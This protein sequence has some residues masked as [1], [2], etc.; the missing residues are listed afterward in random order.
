MD[1]L[2]SLSDGVADKTLKKA[3]AGSFPEPT[4]EEKRDARNT[5]QARFSEWLVQNPP[6][7]GG[8]GRYPNQPPADVSLRYD[9]QGPYLEIQRYHP[10]GNRAKI[11]RGDV[12]RLKGAKSALDAAERVNVE[13][14]AESLLGNRVT[15]ELLDG[16]LIGTMHSRPS[17]EIAREDAPAG[18][19]QPR[20][21]S[22]GDLRESQKIL[23]ERVTQWQV[24]HAGWRGNTRSRRDPPTFAIRQD[25]RG[26]YLEM[27][28]YHP[29]GTPCSITPQDKVRL[30]GAKSAMGAA[31]VLD[32]GVMMESAKA[33]RVLQSLIDKPFHGPPAPAEEDARV[34]PPTPEP[35]PPHPPLRRLR[36]HYIERDRELKA[37]KAPS[38]ARARTS[39]EAR[40]IAHAEQA[41]GKARSAMGEFLHKYSPVDWFSPEM[42]DV[43]YDHFLLRMP[44][45]DAFRRAE[46]L[47]MPPVGTGKRPLSPPNREGFVPPYT[48]EAEPSS[49]EPVPAGSDAEV[50]PMSYDPIAPPR[51]S[52]GRQIIDGTDLVY[53]PGERILA[54]RVVRTFR[55][56]L[57]GRA[58]LHPEK[59]P[60]RRVVQ[61]YKVDEGSRE[62]LN[63]RRSEYDR[64][65]RP[66]PLERETH[67]D[68]TEVFRPGVPE[69]LEWTR[70]KGRAPQESS[71]VEPFRVDVFDV[72]APASLGSR[73]RNLRWDHDRWVVETSTGKVDH[74]VS[75]ARPAVQ[76][77]QQELA[78][79]RPMPRFTRSFAAPFVEG[80]DYHPWDAPA[81]FG[82]LT[83]S[84]RNGLRNHLRAQARTLGSDPP[85]P[86]RSLTEHWIVGDGE[87]EELLLD[88]HQ[89]VARFPPQNEWSQI[90][91]LARVVSE[92][93]DVRKLEAWV[94]NRLWGGHDT[95][96]QD[97]WLARWLAQ[98]WWGDRGG[99]PHVSGG[100][101]TVHDPYGMGPQNRDR[102]EERMRDLE[103]GILSPE[104]VQREIAHLRS[105][106]ERTRSEMF[107]QYLLDWA[108]LLEKHLDE[109]LRRR[110]RTLSGVD[111]DF[112]AGK[113]DAGEIETWA[114]ERLAEVGKPWGTEFPGV[115]T[116]K[117]LAARELL[118]RMDKKGT[119]TP[120][121]EPPSPER[122]PAETGMEAAP[123]EPFPAQDEPIRTR[124]QFARVYSR[125]HD[126]FRSDGNPRATVGFDE[127]AG[128]MGLGPEAFENGQPR[129]ELFKSF[130]E[131]GA[132]TGAFGTYRAVQPYQIVYKRDPSDM[133][134]WAAADPEGGIRTAHEEVP[135]SEEPVPDQGGEGGEDP[136]PTPEAEPRITDLRGR[137]HRIFRDIGKPVTLH[138]AGDGLQEPSYGLW[139]DRDGKVYLWFAS[140]Q[141]D[142]T[143][144]VRGENLLLPG[145]TSVEDA[146]RRVN[147]KGLA[148]SV[149]ANGIHRKLRDNP[150]DPKQPEPTTPARPE[151][152]ARPGPPV[153]RSAPLAREDRGTAPGMEDAYRRLRDYFM[154]QDAPPSPAIFAVLGH[155]WSLPSLLGWLAETEKRRSAFPDADDPLYEAAMDI[156][157]ALGLE[158][159]RPFRSAGY[160]TMYPPKGPMATEM[161]RA[162]E[163]AMD[164][165]EGRMTPEDLRAEIA[166]RRSDV[167]RRVPRSVE[168]ANALEQVLE[169]HL[170]GTLDPSRYNAHLSEGEPYPF[171]RNAP[172]APS[173]PNSSEE[174]VL[175]NAEATAPEEP[176]GTGSGPPK[177]YEDYGEWYSALYHA[178]RDWL[179]LLSLRDAADRP[180]RTGPEVPP[181]PDR[182]ETREELDRR[183]SEAEG[184]WRHLR[185]MMPRALRAAGRGSPPGNGKQRGE[186]VAEVH[187]VAGAAHDARDFRWSVARNDGALGTTVIY[188]GSDGLG[189][190]RARVLRLDGPEANDRYALE[191]HGM[192]YDPP[193]EDPAGP[194]VRAGNDLLWA[195]GSETHDFQEVLED[196]PRSAPALPV[197]RTTDADWGEDDP[198]KF[199]E[200]FEP[201]GYSNEDFGAKRARLL[202]ALYSHARDAGALLAPGTLETLERI[203]NYHELKRLFQRGSRLDSPMDLAAETPIRNRPTSMMYLG[204]EE[205]LVR[206]DPRRLAAGRGE[207][208]RI[209]E[210]LMRYGLLEP[211]G[212]F[213]LNI[214]SDGPRTS[215]VL[216]DAVRSSGVAHR[217]DPHS[218]LN[219]FTHPQTR[220]DQGMGVL[221]NP[222]ETQGGSVPPALGRRIW[223]HLER[224]GRHLWMYSS[225]QDRALVARDQPH[226][227]PDIWFDSHGPGGTVRLRMQRYV[228]RDQAEWS[229]TPSAVET[230]DLGIRGGAAG[231]EEAIK[232]IN[233]GGLVEHIESGGQ[234][235]KGPGNRTVRATYHPLIAE[236]SLPPPNG[237][238]LK[239]HFGPSPGAVPAAEP[240]TVETSEAGDPP[241][242]SSP[243]PVQEGAGTP[244]PPAE[245]PP[246]VETSD[247]YRHVQGIAAD[248]YHRVF[249][250][251]P[252]QHRRGED[253]RVRGEVLD[254]LHRTLDGTG[255]PLNPQTREW[256]ESQSIEDLRTAVE[257]LR[258]NPA[259][260]E[261][262]LADHGLAL[263]PEDP[264]ARPYIQ[265]AKVIAKDRGTIRDLAERFA[266]AVTERAG[267]PFILR[268]SP[269]G[270]VLEARF[271][272]DGD[273]L[274]HYG[275]VPRVMTK[276]DARGRVSR[277]L[278]IGGLDALAD[279][280]ASWSEK[281][282]F[283]P[284]PDVDEG[285]SHQAEAIHGR[286]EQERTTAE[287]R[288]GA[289]LPGNIKRVILLGCVGQKKAGTHK[290]GDLYEGGLWQA[291]R[292]YASDVEASGEHAPT[293]VLS[294]KHGVIPLDQPVESYDETLPD[295]KAGKI[296]AASMRWARSALQ[297]LRKQMRDRYGIDLEQRPDIRIEVHAGANYFNPF[298]AAMGE[299]L[300]DERNPVDTPTRGMGI[301]VQKNWYAQRRVYM[302]RQRAYRDAER[303][304]AEAGSPEPV[305]EEDPAE[306]LR[307]TYIRERG[308]AYQA[309][310]AWERLWRLQKEHAR[311]KEIGEPDMPPNPEGIT[312]EEDLQARIDA[313]RRTEAL[314]DQRANEAQARAEE[315]FNGSRLQEDARRHAMERL[316]PVQDAEDAR[317]VDARV[318]GNVGRT[319]VAKDGRRY[320]I[321]DDVD[322][323]VYAVPETDAIRGEG[324]DDLADVRD[325]GEHEIV[326]PEGTGSRPRPE[327]EQPELF[328]PEGAST[329]GGIS[330]GSVDVVESGEPQQTEGGPDVPPTPELTRRAISDQ[331]AQLYMQRRRWERIRNLINGVGPE[332]P[333]PPNPD[334][335]SSY[336]DA[337]GHLRALQEGM[338]RTKR[339][340]KGSVKLLDRLRYSEGYGALWRAQDTATRHMGPQQDLLDAQWA[341]MA[342]KPESGGVRVGYMVTVPSD[343]AGPQKRYRVVSVG[344]GGELWLAAEVHAD[345]DLEATTHLVRVRPTQVLSTAR[346]H[347]PAPLPSGQGATAPEAPTEVRELLGT[348]GQAEIR[349]ASQGQEHAPATTEDGTPAPV[350][351]SSPAPPPEERPSDPNRH[352]VALDALAAEDPSTVVDSP[353]P[354]QEPPAPPQEASVPPEGG[355]RYSRYEDLPPDL[356]RAM[357]AW[358]DVVNRVMY[359]SEDSPENSAEAERAYNDYSEA[360][361]R[362]GLDEREMN[363]LVMERSDSI[364]NAGNPLFAPE[365]PAPP[366]PARPTPPAQE[367]PAGRTP[368]AEALD[369][370]AGEPSPPADPR[371]SAFQQRA[372]ASRQA[373]SDRRQAYAPE[374]APV[375]EGGRG[376]PDPVA[377]PGPA[378]ATEAI[379][380]ATA[381]APDP[382]PVAT[383]GAVSPEA[384]AELRDLFLHRRELEARYMDAS[385]RGPVRPLEESAEYNEITGRMDRLRSQM[386]EETYRQVYRRVSDPDYVAPEAPNPHREFRSRVADALGPD[387]IADALERMIAED[388]STPAREAPSPAG[389]EGEG[390]DLLYE[391]PLRTW[392]SAPA[393][394]Q[395]PAAPPQPPAAPPQ[396][397]AAPPQSPVA[398]ALDAMANGPATPGAPAPSPAPVDLSGRTV[399]V[400]TRG[401][402]LGFRVEAD[403]YDPDGYVLSRGGLPRRP[404][405]RA[406]LHRMVNSVSAPASTSASTSAPPPASPAPPPDPNAPAGTPDPNAPAGGAATGGAPPVDPNDPAVQAGVPAT[407]PPQTFRQHLRGHA[408][409]GV[410]VGAAHLAER[411]LTDLLTKGNLTDPQGAPL[412]TPGSA[413]ATH[414][415]TSAMHGAALAGGLSALSRW[416]PSLSSALGSTFV[417][418]ETGKA[419]AALDSPL[420]QQDNSWMGS[421]GRGLGNVKD[422]LWNTSVLG[423]PQYATRKL[424]DAKEGAISGLLSPETRER[425]RVS[426]QQERDLALGAWNKVVGNDYVANPLVQFATGGVVAPAQTYEELASRLK[427]ATMGAALLAVPG[428]GGAL[429]AAGRSAMRWGLPALGA[430]AIGAQPA[431]LAY[432]Y[433][434]YGPRNP[435]GVP[436]TAFSDSV[437]DRAEKQGG[438]GYQPGGTGPRV[439]PPPNPPEK[440]ARIDT[441]L[442]GP[443]GPLGYGKDSIRAS[444][445]AMFDQTVPLVREM[446]NLSAAKAQPGNT[447][448]ATRYAELQQQYRNIVNGMTQTFQQ[449]LG[450]PDERKSQIAGWYDRVM[451][452]RSRPEWTPRAR[453]DPFVPADQRPA[454]PAG[455]LY[456]PERHTWRNEGA[457]EAALRQKGWTPE[458]SYGHTTVLDPSTLPPPRRT[459]TRSSF[460]DGPP[461]VAM[462]PTDLSD[463][464]DGM[465]VFDAAPPS[466]IPPTVAA[467]LDLLSGYHA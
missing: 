168:W 113:T 130:L 24:Y 41:L 348:D 332:D 277:R 252:S 218:N 175:D 335:I 235:R 273:V 357:D 379:P 278:G 169:E 467:A 93:G 465:P 85:D 164:L 261:P 76:G 161:D 346:H 459:G 264:A 228:H 463:L 25:S 343:S 303:R 167:G 251:P 430:T 77:W 48:P 320:R 127:V 206:K 32:I 250:V 405:A 123:A 324:M 204:S 322:G 287:A 340:L 378:A 387:R 347:T 239:M 305:Q 16:P 323:E 263:D 400:P 151:D 391:T 349:A 75:E 59:T 49:P 222:I 28:R 452:E 355:P 143:K 82:A 94:I 345:A 158:S 377:A 126:A 262:F 148:E 274:R 458:R 341:D 450:I 74:T 51:D 196:V 267:H 201:Q 183:I 163:R 79:G 424:F 435:A 422:F 227:L 137:V 425:L 330:S 12:V 1:E 156:R 186:A 417:A 37:L 237:T 399:M 202:D 354:A 173:G 246:P 390:F 17:S 4:K 351:P 188:T 86:D 71:E 326:N 221:T 266:R 445:H 284:I 64:T 427:G 219:Y 440:Q 418:G 433:L 199:R 247:P 35:L 117:A 256:L 243:E 431:G 102:T 208:A 429:G 21:F 408:G 238:P 198:W 232:R 404:I 291:R 190:R 325:L 121:A 331:Y 338:N 149:H 209:E 101:P 191:P 99:R 285:F 375:S 265:K 98:E 9:A 310:R 216:E 14:L 217:G 384:E 34:D 409:L 302:E 144:Q 356:Q 103:A 388:P 134:A 249:E 11:T 432:E 298:I 122:V 215:H 171:R 63:A 23:S 428:A 31:R 166:H 389:S 333:M 95:G 55:P 269:E 141:K 150:L 446:N 210:R 401:G 464:L 3:K 200:M 15:K 268:L 461:E 104:R 319:M 280:V 414:L 294:A 60:G 402:L 271:Q 413:I 444:I 107:H 368:E 184:D 415:P 451:E 426:Q 352:G 10:N 160:P 385:S 275:D 416:L 124:D 236:G 282:G 254:A 245:T 371:L 193:G 129:S 172:P 439:V 367:A 386:G 142:P 84:E 327:V 197:S 276:M 180:G 403:P 109:A 96:P 66:L 179:R 233:I 286:R 128:V 381:P 174:P 118:R 46:D 434:A 290:A 214:L 442:A 281:G 5:L 111:R 329:E 383:G 437:A 259:G 194:R 456:T 258:N 136:L 455:V 420:V 108:D 140:V 53:L 406:V 373:M 73:G 88:S 192:A 283:R 396:P 361:R 116:G 7:R 30:K 152:K 315:H 297:Q 423:L 260:L 114:N 394:E 146:A 353:A 226:A 139:M 257:A 6:P 110:D 372:A 224:R 68:Q 337:W 20:P 165:K 457:T 229:H 2:R 328:H 255:V 195:G 447:A 411:V 448:A 441:F 225:G 248:L 176:A 317:W 27:Q 138:P 240:P 316:A 436:R 223:D 78:A 339:Q 43:P 18:P 38:A 365:P 29:N 62:E 170:S 358:A 45:E 362:H 189:P 309:V 58:D 382:A 182:I 157:R 376:T 120:G 466:R 344:E 301:G 397:P 299:T 412:V 289:R 147:L 311:Y 392:T 70:E 203:D 50:R 241:P 419:A 449:H 370:L 92:T 67:W 230:W 47:S 145:A 374:P 54:V 178:K 350:A 279:T 288:R 308:I 115:R 205:E 13:A 313:A 181:N 438:G 89:S 211:S 292:S 159:D 97:R 80:A 244:T 314:A 39:E 306:A 36:E 185:D 307:R 454:D 119:Y 295:A 131:W 57:G 395:P 61:Y 8:A 231:I 207:M 65:S 293:F 360:L 52:A 155:V 453:F 112:H 359:G 312:D 135:P 213:Y 318:G 300:S 380:V 106:A 270:D 69:W 234:A 91:G 42:G 133:A 81:F 336:E 44:P 242:P 304:R 460:L 187:R 410:G 462:L 443:Q 22:D 90:P 26:V 321:V 363:G 100:S 342:G 253:S 334:G 125:V 366:V 105:R 83:S 154:A 132:R 364:R 72:P 19:G 212:A 220:S 398:D 33:G 177:D 272:G 162:W 153:P 40:R 87:S 407:A 421:L 393:A 296:P 56:G 369:R